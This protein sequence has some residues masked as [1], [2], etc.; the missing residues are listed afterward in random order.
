M[1][2]LRLVLLLLHLL[3]FAALT[4]GLLLQLREPEKKV[5]SLM[6]DGAGTVFVSGILMVGVLEGLDGV[7]V[8]HAKIG[9]KLVLALVVLALVMANLRKPSISKGLF[10]IISL[11]TVATLLVA[12]FWSPAHKVKE[13]VKN[14][15]K[16]ASQ[17]LVQH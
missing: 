5:N 3:G 14:D 7:E 11:L 10:G 13:P 16:A 2:I 12:I 8:N 15:D 4:G 6:R 9:V 1:D 17:V